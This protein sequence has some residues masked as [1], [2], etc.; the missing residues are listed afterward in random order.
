MRYLYM[1]FVVVLL[2]AVPAW[3]SMAQAELAP[4]Q[5]IPEELIARLQKSVT[6]IEDID[7]VTERR[8]ACKNIV[9]R[10]ES[11]LDKYSTAI[12]R[13]RLLGIVFEIRKVM[14]TMRQTDQYRAAL[15]A[16]A[17]E[18]RKAPDEYAAIR[19]E[20][21]VLLQEIE[22]TKEDGSSQDRALAIA[23][24]ADRY[25]GTAAEAE[26]LMMASMVA[27]DIGH[28]ALLDAFRKSLSKRFGDDPKVSA[29]LRE[30]F[31]TS[32]DLRF[33]G[34]FQRADGKSISFLPG[35]IYVLCFW[36]KDTPFLDQRIAEVKAAQD[37][38]KGKFEVF[39]FNLDQRSDGGKGILKRMKL[40]WIPM[41]LPE[42][43]ESETFSAVGGVNLFSAL[44]VDPHGW[45]AGNRMGQRPASLHKK[46]EAAVESPRRLALLR[47]LK[48]GDFLVA[49]PVGSVGIKTNDT[50]FIAALGEI[51]SCF[52][53]P[54][55]RYRLTPDES[56]RNYEKAERLCGQAIVK[57]VDTPQLWRIYNRRVI[58]LRG[59]W[60]LSCDPEYL[61]RAV[62]SAKAALAMDMPPDAVTVPQFCLATAALSRGDAL[63]AKVLAQFI[64]SA[65]GK[66]ASG[67]AYA[68]AL[69]L[70]VDHNSRDQYIKYRNLLLTEYVEDPATWWVASFLFD[71]SSALR[72]Y[73][74]ALPGRGADIPESLPYK[75]M[76]K[77]DFTT[78]DGDKVIFQEATGGKL[79]VVLF[80]EQPRDTGAAKLQKEMGDFMVQTLSDRHLSDIELLGVFR[81]NS[82]A[83][84]AARMQKNKWNFDAVSVN[85]VD[86]R[87]LCREMGILAADLRPN[88]FIIHPDGSIML[89]L[90]GASFDTETTQKATRR[91]SDAIRVYDRGQAAAALMVDDYREYVDRLLSSFPPKY[92]R[93]PRWEPEWRV[94]N[95]H[96]RKL[97][98][99]YIQMKEWQK[100][101]DVVNTSIR[102]HEKNCHCCSVQL[103]PLFHRAA[104][105]KELG[106]EKEAAAALALAKAGMCPPGSKV[107]PRSMFPYR[108]MM[109][110]HDLN[111][112][113]AFVEN[114]M[115]DSTGQKKDD[116]LKLASD[117]LMRAEILK[118][119]SEPTE[120]AKDLQRAIALAWPYA[121]TMIDPQLDMKACALRRTLA[122][123]YM[124]S[125]NWQKALDCINISINGHEAMPI[126]NKQHCR[127][128]AMQVVPLSLRVQVLKALGRD[129]EMENARTLA[130]AAI[131]PPGCKEQPRSS[132]PYRYFRA[133]SKQELRLKYVDDYLRE[134][135]A[136]PENWQHRFGL[137]ADLQLRSQIMEQQGHSIEAD[138]DRKRATALIWPFVSQK[139]AG[140]YI[141][142]TRYVDIV[143]MQ[144]P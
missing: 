111:Q 95:A 96:R 113:L 61:K 46:Y 67:V 109:G 71:Q 6:T 123:Q 144:D 45:A 139:D 63:P 89:A 24:L 15:L 28:H 112:R 12:D 36:S 114:Y 98:W 19:L 59:M 18:L 50:S 38:Y 88:V 60:R 76:F 97:V 122:S 42:G 91:I 35:Q 74:R 118:Q 84:V 9:R 93:R 131:C 77:A 140:S 32:N 103:V 83:T 86:W 33:R 72:L 30:R 52:M 3:S 23:E 20:A 133:P 143:E 4:V 127:I 138:R 62:V 107:E 69:M 137:S 22:L 78:L 81:S 104:V 26:S 94:P 75:R 64:E 90:S 21:D 130:E 39:S 8:R 37:R 80:M 68:A 51:N 102:E 79:K 44:V 117:L 105:L 5:H 29:F 11:L 17:M 57:Q 48:I 129:K 41:L 31:A 135:K 110:R 136:G 128:C 16:T 53:A 55:R 124:Q 119:L 134:M 1:F 120:S 106:R 65:G 43:S 25:R 82:V 142:P 73:G 99:A 70:A 92:R 132:F 56:F 10:A 101:L 40:D 121:P 100:A 85:D 13:F 47:S 116:R 126:A 34:T 49:D 7:S 54:P 27:F 58:A 2:S 141:P 87:V 115:R 14:F 108:Q 66:Q 125:Q